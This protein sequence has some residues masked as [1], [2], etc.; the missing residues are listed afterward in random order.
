MQ[1]TFI[2][3]LITSILTP[4]AV[5]GFVSFILYKAFNLGEVHQKLL[6]AMEDLTEMKLNVKDL[7]N[8]IDTL[9]M[10]TTV[11]KT[12]LISDLDMDAALFNAASPISLTEKGSAII[13]EVSFIDIYNQ[14]KNEFLNKIK[15][16][17][18]KTPA[19]IDE[20]CTLIMYDMKD[21]PRLNHFKEI[22]YEHGLIVDVLLRA[23]AI[24]LREEA[25]KELL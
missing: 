14:N 9:K 23:C 11:I 22:A 13:E 6:S 10:D 2:Q 20:A 19:D 12:Y 17:N 1:D 18:V 3:Y 8:S 7:T 16:H 24:Y 21:D 4:S 25:I 15:E 5:I